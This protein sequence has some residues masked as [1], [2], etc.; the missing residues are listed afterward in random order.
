MIEE[1]KGYKKLIVWQEAKKLVVLIYRL[2]DS[3]PK[4]EDFGLKSQMRRA[5]VSIIANLA[6]GW[7]RRS[8]KD[9]LH[10]L[11]ISEGSL[12]E[13]ETEAEV[14]VAVKYWKE[15]EFKEFEQQKVKV[16]YL[17]FKYKEKIKNF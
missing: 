10:Y 14:T 1:Q 8:S 4:S 7:L 9:K 5:A 2:T 15:D 3:L 13:L 11:E 17:L 16:G 6:E 12:L